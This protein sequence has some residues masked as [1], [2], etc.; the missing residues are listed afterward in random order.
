M[1]RTWKKFISQRFY[2]TRYFA[3]HWLALSV[4][5]AMLWK[6]V[7]ISTEIHFNLFHFLLVPL[8]IFPGIMIPVFMHNCAHGN[9]RNQ[10]LN[11]F[12]GEI[13]A[14]F[15][16]MSLGIVRIN[17]TLHHAFSD[18]DH[19][20]HPPGKQSFL[21]FF[22]LSQFAGSG[23]IEERFLESHG[24]SSLNRFVFNLN[25]LLHYGSY[26]LRLTC[27]YLILG[28]E[29]FMTFFIPSYLIFSF[30]FAHVNYVTHSQDPD[31]EVRILNKDDNL[32]YRFINFIGSGIYYH[33]EHHRNPKLL[34][35][36]SSSLRFRSAPE[37]SSIEAGE[38]A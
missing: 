22:F 3:L 24:R 12:L 13:A 5:T 33:R 29:L 35:P 15:C 21:R 16:L 6:Y 19:D 9:H 4:L 38:V 8:C 10:F 23:V 31:G 28:P 7:G 27:W 14:S 32:Y 2:L 37:T 36:K 18:T 11:N 26:G 20:P 30:G 17:H 1:S 34:N 25:R